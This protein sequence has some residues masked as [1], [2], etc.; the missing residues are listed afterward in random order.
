MYRSHAGGLF[1][2][3]CTLGAE[4]TSAS[5][6]H[7]QV[8]HQLSRYPYDL[9]NILRPKPA[10]L[11]FLYLWLPPALMGHG[12]KQCPLPSQPFRAG[13]QMLLLWNGTRSAQWK[14]LHGVPRGG[15]SSWL[16]SGTDRNFFACGFE[17]RRGEEN[18]T[19]TLQPA[20]E[21][22]PHCLRWCWFE[23]HSINHLGG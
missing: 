6:T 11:L 10:D 21:G 15:D 9:N 18:P 8:T 7:A 4:K 20:Q 16:R 14:V 12:K 17:S 5:Y 23:A 19:V 3:A 1:S 22:C 2:H 13:L